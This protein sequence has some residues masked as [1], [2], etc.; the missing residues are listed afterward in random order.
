MALEESVWYV[1][2]PL[3]TDE[4]T[5]ADEAVE[6]LQTAWENWE[7]N[8]GD[9]EVVLTEALAAFA[10]AAAQQAS[11]ATEEI[12]RVFGTEL[13]GVPYQDGAPAGTTVTFARCWSTRRRRAARTRSPTPTISAS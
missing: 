2:V 13:V 11:V 1:E 4:T 7:P 6:A 8:E 12:F 9:L 3:E 5:L 10:A